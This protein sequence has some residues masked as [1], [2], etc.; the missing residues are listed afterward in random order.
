MY[1]DKSPWLDL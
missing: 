1:I